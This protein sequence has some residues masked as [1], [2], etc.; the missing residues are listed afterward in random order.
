M[1]DGVG[2]LVLLG[3]VCSAHGVRG[4]VKIKTYTQDP[5]NIASYGPVTNGVDSFVVSVVSVL[6][7]S[8]VIAKIDGV[9]DRNTAGSLRNMRLYVGH[10][11]LPQTQDDEFYMNILIGMKVKLSDDTM[12]GQ[13]VDVSNFG[14]CDI[15]EV[16]TSKGKKVMF[17]F[18]EDIFPTL[19]K[20]KKEITI[21]LPEVIGACN[22]F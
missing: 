18:T 16:E 19:D 17:P 22:D 14:S 9:Y 7:D 21:V 11:C 2:S 4:H 12:Y 8:C 3:V 6:H 20:Q 10:S 5:R 13:V 1:N 15:V